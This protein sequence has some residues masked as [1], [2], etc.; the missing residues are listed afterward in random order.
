M[1]GEGQGGD[2]GCL[3]AWALRWGGEE[4]RERERKEEEA[5]ASEHTKKRKK[6][7]SIAACLS[8]P[9]T[10]LF[11]TKT[12]PSPSHR[13]ARHA[14]RRVSAGGGTVPH[15]GARGRGECVCCGAARHLGHDT[16]R[17]KKMRWATDLEDPEIAAAA[18][19][20]PD[21]L[22]RAVPLRTGHAARVASHAG[23][24]PSSGGLPPSSGRAAASSGSRRPGWPDRPVLEGP[25]R[26]GLLPSAVWRTGWDGRHGGSRAGGGSGGHSGAAAAAA[27]S[28]PPPPPPPL[29]TPTALDEDEED[30]DDDA[31]PSTSYATSDSD[32]RL[33]SAKL[34][35]AGGI[36]GAVS[37]TATAPLARLTILYQVQ[38]TAAAAGSPLAGLSLGAAMRAVVARDGVAALWRGNGVTI[39]E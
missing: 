33:E 6:K 27:D 23:A 30:D 10:P 24:G 11:L 35:A 32:D 22:E 39:G 14:S 20:L 28:P 2:G 4:K 34:L 29:T 25:G 36:A 1:V 19:D 26:G 5:Y 31:S 38:G 8:S 7:Q 16:K 21:H 13:G 17:N 37:K 15:T 18:D 12:P 3:C 9:P